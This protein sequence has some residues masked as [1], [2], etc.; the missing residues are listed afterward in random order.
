MQLDLLHHGLLSACLYELLGH[1][2]KDRPGTS[3]AETLCPK[4]SVW[5]NSADALVAHPATTPGSDDKTA[6]RCHQQAETQ[7]QRS[8][9]IDIAEAARLGR[10][11]NELPASRAKVQRSRSLTTATPSKVAAMSHHP[12]NAPYHWRYH[13]SIWAISSLW[14]FTMTAWRSRNS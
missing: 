13:C 1:P 9:V 3:D 11:T 7:L 5:S 10:E 12:Y 8:I 4:Q 14:T 2:S 6:T